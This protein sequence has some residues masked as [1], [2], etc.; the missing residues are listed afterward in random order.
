MH[1][2]LPNAPSV[3]TG[4][5]VGHCVRLSALCLSVRLSARPSVCPSARPERRPRFNSLRILAITLT[6]GEMMQSIIEQIAN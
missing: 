1:L 3:P 5:V 2:F 6:L 4:I